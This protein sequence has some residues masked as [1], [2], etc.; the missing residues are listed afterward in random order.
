MNAHSASAIAQ[1][2]SADGRR[3]ANSFSPKAATAAACSQYT[4]IGLSKRG[5]PFSVVCR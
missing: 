1:M 2:L 5:S 4:P 3:N